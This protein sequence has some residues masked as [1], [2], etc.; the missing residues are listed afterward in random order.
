ML[1]IFQSSCNCRSWIEQHINPTLLTFY[2]FRTTCD[3]NSLSACLPIAIYSG[4]SRWWYDWFIVF[5]QTICSSLIREIKNNTNKLQVAP[6][7]IV[8]IIKIWKHMIET[9][10]CQ[11]DILDMVTLW[12]SYHINKNINWE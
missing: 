5:L 6:Y 2:W 7:M 8:S 9:K 1:D 10:I 4:S 3:D 12:R 11:K